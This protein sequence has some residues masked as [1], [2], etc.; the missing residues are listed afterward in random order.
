MLAV[1][2]V[3]FWPSLRLQQDQMVVVPTDMSMI[4][5]SSDQCMEP[6]V[7]ML[8][9]LLGSQTGQGHR[10]LAMHGIQKSRGGHWVSGAFC[11]RLA[12]HAP[13]NVGPLVVNAVMVWAEGF[14]VVAQQVAC[15][16]RCPGTRPLPP[17][18]RCTLT[19]GCGGRDTM[20]PLLIL[21]SQ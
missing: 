1:S 18:F 5:H 21:V 17:G 4:L 15:R 14:F 9:S 11:W 12:R 19:P 8:S 3:R 16:T 2:K 6:L 20:R 7:V 10:S 13:I